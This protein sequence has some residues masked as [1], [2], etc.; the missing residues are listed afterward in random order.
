MLS[1]P[2]A[3]PPARRTWEDQVL[4]SEQLAVITDQLAVLSQQHEQM[5]QGQQALCA[6]WVTCVRGSPDW[7][8][9]WDEVRRAH[10]ARQTVFQARSY[11]HTE[12]IALVSQLRHL[13]G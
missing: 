2:A 12:Y 4:L 11:C 6:Q 7:C 8:H 9:L 10:A 3:P 13:R 1:S 5:C